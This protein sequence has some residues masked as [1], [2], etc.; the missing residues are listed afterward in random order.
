MSGFDALMPFAADVRLIGG[1]NDSWNVLSTS[2]AASS[3]PAVHV[4]SK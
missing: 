3:R 1:F 4:I 2:R